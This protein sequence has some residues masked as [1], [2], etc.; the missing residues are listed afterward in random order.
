MHEITSLADVLPEELKK[1]IIAYNESLD[2]K[3]IH[4]LIFDVT[5]RETFT[6]Y[7]MVCHGSSDR[8]VQAVFE[9]IEVKMKANGILPIGFEG[10][11]LNHWTLMDYGGLVIHI[12][13]EPLREFY[14][15]EGLWSDCP[16]VDIDALEVLKSEQTSD[17]SDE[18]SSLQDAG[19][20]A[21]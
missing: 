2:K 1:L 11:S 9:G 4:P 16:R 13:Y 3:A 18:D 10:E 7:I 15:I 21:S 8:H 5:E 19:D 12:F 6:D 20:D 17:S 14:D